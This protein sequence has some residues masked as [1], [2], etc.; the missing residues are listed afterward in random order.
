MCVI[1]S[2]YFEDQIELKPLLIFLKISGGF[3]PGSERTLA[4]YLKHAS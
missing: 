2:H 1:V 3:D 4:V